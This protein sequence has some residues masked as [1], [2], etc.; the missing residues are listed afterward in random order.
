MGILV[1]KMTIEE[2]GEKVSSHT[3]LYKPYDTHC[4][5]APTAGWRNEH[6]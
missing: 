5:I 6:W 1:L 3:Q 2:G 4:N